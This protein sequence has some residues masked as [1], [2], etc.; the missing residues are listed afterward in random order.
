MASVNEPAEPIVIDA[1][2]AVSPGNR[3]DGHGN[4][5]V[6]AAESFNRSHPQYEVRVRKVEAHLMPETVVEAIEQGNPPDIAEYYSITTQSALDTRAA[7]GEPMFTPLERAI[8]GRD[9]ILGEPVLIDDLIPT[10][11]AHYSVGGELVSMPSFVSTNILYANQEMLDRAGIERMPA[12]WEELTEACAA[13][14][15]LPDGPAHSVSWPNYG[16]LFHMEIAGQGGLIGNHG[17]GRL[18]RATRVRLDSPEVLNYVRW[19][20]QMQDSGYYLATEELHYVTAMQAF[21]NKEIAFVVSSTAVG[22]STGEAAIEA[23]IDLTVGH[24]ARHDA[25]S[26]PGGVPAGGSFFLTAGLS[27]EKEDGALAFI[28]HQ[29]NPQHEMARVSDTSTPVTSLPMTQTLYALATSGEWPEP[30]PGFRVAT[31]Q[32]AS[33]KLTPGAAG[34]LI[35]NLN[36]IYTAIHEAIEDVV[37]NGAEPAERFRTATEQAQAA[38]DRHNE[39]ALAYPPVTPS[40]LRAG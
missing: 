33:A 6:N 4:P 30:F 29:L 23:G 39:A 20:K 25:L 34:P 5:L 27:P 31:E 22:K 10:V 7:D 40:E 19:W 12:T 35:G 24:L 18:G 36:G 38:L 17:N 9:K 28:Q 2:I 8:A 11:R 21:L 15:A 14:A 37:L 26:S 1:W 16:W 3:L 13:I 32:V